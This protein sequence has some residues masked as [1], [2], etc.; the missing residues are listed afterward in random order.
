MKILGVN[1]NLGANKPQPS[2]SIKKIVYTEEQDVAP[3]ALAKSEVPLIKEIRNKDWVQYGEDNLAP[4]M[5]SN[6]RESCGLH[7]AII[8][9][10]AM[11]IAGKNVKVTP[12]GEMS[13]SDMARLERLVNEPFP[14]QGTLNEMVYDL[15]FQLSEQGAFAIEA[16]RNIL[17][18]TDNAGPEYTHFK[19]I[20][21][22][23]VRSGKYETDGLVHKYYYSR[24]WADVNN[25]TPRA[26]TAFQTWSPNDKDAKGNPIPAP[27]KEIAYY[28]R[29][30]TG[31][32]YYGVPRYIA[33]LQ[34]IKINVEM[35]V[36]HLSNLENG[37][38]P[39]IIFRFFRKPE[40]EEK[41][42][43]I[44]EGLKKSLSGTNKTGKAIVIFSDDKE[45][46]AEVE[47][48]Q[49]NG[50]DK[51]LLLLG[52]QVVQEILSGH[53]VTTPGLMGI[54]IPGKLGYSTELETGY[55]IYDQ[56]VITPDQ[57]F[58]EKAL[59]KHFKS[60]GLNV[61]VEIE[62]LNPLL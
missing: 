44:V 23:K 50:L 46:G 39:S 47:P 27:Q 18:G 60:I 52:E 17:F 38:N 33:C 10:K 58:I 59:K 11:M 37:Y 30:I 31:V 54:P 22:S 25:H 7:G 34:W 14:G 48:F 41:K 21:V 1:I 16:Q 20:D 2:E 61:N 51:Q 43:R 4:Q 29:K 24:N 12:I 6:L 57:K 32:E 19:T 42:R 35:G 13:Q 28:K 9:S 26:Y 36:F 53:S 56:T 3:I 55:K 45:N 8:H 5:Y 15:A 62:K 49:V 40:N